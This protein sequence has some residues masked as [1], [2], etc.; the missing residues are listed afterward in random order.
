MVYLA[1]T[2]RDDEVILNRLIN[3]RLFGAVPK[4]PKFKEK[5]ELSRSRGIQK[6]F[7]K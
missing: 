5:S 4:G 1:F 7:R 6:S 3:F 2:V